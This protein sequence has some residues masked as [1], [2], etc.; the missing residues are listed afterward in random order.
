MDTIPVILEKIL[1]SITVDLASQEGTEWSISKIELSHVHTLYE[2][3]QPPFKKEKHFLYFK[4]GFRIRIRTTFGSWIRIRIRVKSGSG[5]A[6]KSKF[7]SFRGSGWSLGG[8]W[9][10]KMEAW[11][12]KKWRPGGFRASG[13]RFAS[14]WWCRIRILIINGSRS[15]SAEKWKAGSGKNSWINMHH[16]ICLLLSKYV[17]YKAYTEHFNWL[18]MTCMYWHA[19]ENI[20]LQLEFK[21][22]CATLLALFSIRA[23]R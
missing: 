8:P 3:W 5:S 22:K 16:C 13:R 12:L 11:R 17:K 19:C 7:R 9:T 23:K 10:L 18:L 6:I 20:C 21:Q 4:A 14:P 1:R 2:Y 15:G